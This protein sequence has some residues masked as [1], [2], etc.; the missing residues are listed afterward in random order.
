MRSRDSRF[1]NLRPAMTRRPSAAAGA[2]AAALALLAVSGTAHALGG[3]SPGA[4]SAQTVKL[5]SGPGSVRGLAE[6]AQV[7]SF[8]GQVQY[9]VPIDLPA[10]P[11]G[12]APQLSL[13]YAGELGNGPLGVGWMLS[14][15]G[16]R[17][18]LRLGVPSYT[19][20]DELE[21]SGL[22]AG[23]E[24]VR[25]ADGTYRLEAQGQSA[26]GRMIDGGFEV[27]A[28][29]GT[30]YRLGV[31]ALGRKAAGAQV[32]SWYLEEV[33]NVSGQTIEYRY[34]QAG[35]EV[36]LSEVLWGPMVNGAR[37][38]RAEVRYETRPD[39]VVSYRTGFR[40]E[41]AQRIDKIV[42][43]SFGGPQRVIDLSYEAGFALSRLSSVRVT[44]PDGLDVLPQLSLRYMAATS[45]VM[46]TVPNVS[47]WVLNGNGTSLFDVDDDGVMDLLRLTTTGHS[48]RRNL[49]GSFDVARAVPGAA[50]ASLTSVRLLDLTGD[51]G[52]EMVWQQGTQWKVF[53]LA[54]SNVA[55]KNWVP[56]GNWAGATNLPLSSVAVADLDGDFRMDVLQVSGSSMQVRMGSESGLGAAVLMGAIDPARPTVAPGNSATSF[57]DING[58]GLADAVY[59]AGSAMY[60]YL[61]KGDGR[62]EKVR[63]VAYPWTGAFDLT[64][65]RTGDLDR[66]GLMDLAIVR[67]GNVA[68][69]R[70]L[71]NGTVMTTPIQLARPPGTDASVVVALAD[72]NG[73]GSEDLVWSSSAG[74]WLLD[75]AG[76]TSAGMLTSIDNGL[77]QT[78]TFGYGASAQL[79]L[80]AEAA[81]TPWTLGMPISIPVTVQQRRTFGSG[82]PARSIRLDVRDGIYDRGE[83]RFI[84]FAEAIVTRPDP[85]DGAPA[86]DTVRQLQRFSTGPG[87]DRSLRGQVLLDRIESG[88]GTLLRETVYTATTMAIAGLPADQPKLRK[89]IVSAVEERHHEGQTTPI[90]TRTELAYDAEGRKIEEKRLGR[91]DLVGDENLVRRTYTNGRS[92]RG[93]RDLLC[94]EKLFALD[95][96][97]ETLSAHAQLLYGDAAAIAPLCDAGAGWQRVKRQYLTGEARWVNLT[98]ASYDASGNRVQS[99]EEG[100]TRTLEYDAYGVHPVAEL[101]NATPTRQLR[102]EMTWDNVQAQ[103]ASMRDSAGVTTLLTYD[104]VGRIRTMARS[105]QPPHL[106]YRYSASGPRPYTETFVFDGPI[107]AVTANPATWTPASRWRHTVAVLTSAGEPLFTATRLGTTSWLVAERR[108]RDALGRTTR[109]ADAF[110]QPGTVAELVASALPAGVPVQTLTYD[111]LDRPTGQVLASG[112]RTTY[113]YR[114]FESVRTTDGMAPVT[115]WLDGQNRIRRTSRTVNS[116]EEQVAATYDAA[117]RITRMTLPHAAGVVEHTYQYDGLGRLS[118]AQDPDIGVRQ[119]GYDDAGHLTSHRNGAGQTTT[120]GYDGAGRLTRS[121]GHDGAQFLYHYDDALDAATFQ[122]TAS[123]LAWV[124]EPTGTVQLGYDAFGQLARM[125]R[126]VAGKTADQTTV[127]AASGLVLSQSDGS[128]LDF[129]LAYDAAGRANGISSAAIGGSGAVW[130]LE[131]QDA[132]GRPLRESFGNG[133]VQTY[134]R[135][136]L[137]QATKLRVLRPAGAAL[138]DVDVGYNPYGAIATVGDVDGRGLDHT[139][140][141]TYDAA[142]RLTDA[143]L[144]SGVNAFQMRYRYDGLQNMVRREATGPRALGISL[145]QYR[146]G[147]PDAGGAP[148]GPRQLTSILPDPAAGSPPGT[149][150]LTLDYDGAGRTTRQGAMTLAYNGFDQLTSV[151]GVPGGGTVTHAYG[152]DGTRVRSVAAGG[153]QTLWFSPEVSEDQNGVRSYDVRIGDR[154]VA[155]I[156]RNPAALAA[157]ARAETIS[158]GAA[159][160]RGLWI[161]LGG[162]GAL[163]L[164]VA[165]AMP[166]RARRAHGTRA[167]VGAFR[168]R[169]RAAGSALTLASFVLTGCNTR[170]LSVEATEEGE[171]GTTSSVLY[172]HQAIGAG[173]ALVTRADGSLFEERRYEPYGAP[174]DSYT[175]AAGTA[176]PGTTGTIDFLRDPHNSLN[177]QSDAATGWS[178]HGARWMA[179]ELARWQTPDPPVKAPSGRFMTSPWD[180]NPY[181][182]VNQNPVL[183]WDPDGRDKLPLPG[184][185]TDLLV[186]DTDTSGHKLSTDAQAVLGPIFQRAWGFDVSKVTVHFGP[187]PEGAAA[188][189][190]G[191][192]VIIDKG[193]WEKISTQDQLGLLG[194]EIT[195]SVQYERLAAPGVWSIGGGLAAGALVG[196]VVYGVA[197]KLDVKTESSVIAAIVFGVIAA[198]IAFW[199]ID[200]APLW[201]R[202]AGESK[203]PDNYGVP[204]D[205]AAI[206][207]NDLDPTDKRFTLDQMGDRT[208]QEIDSLYDAEKASGSGP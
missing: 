154:L 204:S 21:V 122:H 148:R 160:A 194:H 188:F 68:W 20:A 135:N 177:K 29:D 24:I 5:P 13:G 202:Y 144:G 37:A 23:G 173:P 8:T 72:G 81:G 205:L 76:A 51:S 80:A 89:A 168:L 49:G 149:P 147:E 78:Q 40:V 92:A 65:I 130:Q 16:I 9:S 17:R 60:L 193:Y 26:V 119:L 163:L 129:S 36:Y 181:Q 172:Y 46:Q 62:F 141:F 93:V 54:G 146:Y 34:Q 14:Q 61:G 106:E 178:D 139:A 101:V 125:R 112:A 50:G 15:T 121:T 157:A 113:A 126:V 33:R 52:A 189:A 195:H 55:D 48:Y 116:V 32:A 66:D 69:Y 99:T 117:G 182:Y 127:R 120:Y 198:A 179:P 105:G 134:Q 143:T 100:V 11:G 31:T 132:S 176:G 90:V 18:S 19:D 169:L 35:G 170:A 107:G 109:L 110:E 42:V 85:A 64:Q 56:L 197:K 86:A 83:R 4:V 84:G 67:A 97:T 145:G 187:V 207:L 63:D 171:L 82:E 108:Q 87:L 165:L 103:P 1:G 167:A 131:Q 203:R 10:G 6:D 153:G 39:A 124:E 152:Y 151:S 200:K 58:D 7:S 155:R 70:G 79:A 201:R 156:V 94:E 38:F 196:G 57:P 206:Q 47:G 111:A 118:V 27:T 59:L 28:A 186:Q 142:A 136:L 30:V 44:S 12:F 164:L 43:W 161:A 183:Y 3:P 185:G 137:G 95:G 98:Q 2:T 128:G 123:R 73:N 102:W 184:E 45:G 208:T 140:S 104:G 77:G 159:I 74:M 158:S 138:Y 96:A 53:Q 190:V 115:R 199:A 25:L 192:T 150:T 75:F 162:G 91:L 174:I 88:T 133:V 114:A 175:E 180:L 22:G 191:N 71:A 166:R 41:S